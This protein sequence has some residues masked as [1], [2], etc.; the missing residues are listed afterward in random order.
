M[1][2]P[3]NFG[4][5]TP[6]DANFMPQLQEDLEGLAQYVT[7]EMFGGVGD[8]TTNDSPAFEAA[9]T[10]LGDRGGVILLGPKQYLFDTGFTVTNGVVIVG[11]NYKPREI[12][13]VFGGSFGDTSTVIYLN[14]GELYTWEAKTGLINTSVLKTGMTAPTTN[15]EANALVA[16]FAGRAITIAG[17]EIIMQNLFIGGFDQAMSWDDP[18]T[19]GYARPYITGILFDCNNGIK[20]GDIPDWGLIEHIKAFPMLT[21]HGELLPGFPAVADGDHQ[22]HRRSGIAM[23]FIKSQGWGAV[24]DCN[25]FGWTVGFKF[26][27]VDNCVLV[28][29]STDN[30]A[31]GVLPNDSIGFWLLGNSKIVLIGPTAAGQGNAVRVETTSAGSFCNISGGLFFD[32]STHIKI[33][34]TGGDCYFTGSRFTNVSDHHGEETEPIWQAASTGV[35]IVADNTFYDPD[36]TYPGGNAFKV[37]AGFFAQRDNIFNTCAPG[38]PAGLLVA[39]LP[40]AANNAGNRFFVRDATV[41]AAGN[42]GNVVAG[43]GGNFVPVYCDGANWRIG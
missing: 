15:A 40:T 3:W 8:G 27:D 9:Q 16:S 37:D 14:P 2:L 7:L 6:Y 21:F 23:E 22:L 5:G 34:S 31:Y 25:I 24:R 18:L 1:P 30:D 29:C 36:T 12:D 42:F 20:I 19:N 35:T 10:S 26:T 11:Q 13:A 41:V 38:T 32:N 33:N 43:T 28:D 17:D 39:S 4:T